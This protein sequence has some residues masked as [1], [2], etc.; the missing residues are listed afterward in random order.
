MC[1]CSSNALCPVGVANKLSG[2]DH[3]PCRIASK[4]ARSRLRWCCSA[5]CSSSVRSRGMDPSRR[6]NWT[7]PA[8]LQTCGIL[9][10]EDV[11][12]A[13]WERRVPFCSLLLSG[14]FV[15]Y[16]LG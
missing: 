16:V 14:C 11:S 10:C 13:A 6:M 5:T 1:V 7:K 12:R 2:L 8:P 9:T 3:S 15:L 4:P